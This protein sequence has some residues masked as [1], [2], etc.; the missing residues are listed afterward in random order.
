MLSS[1]R[2][3]MLV[4]RKTWPKAKNNNAH[5]LFWEWWEIKETTQIDKDCITHSGDIIMAANKKFFSEI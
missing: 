1:W 4:I 5:R 2:I 3:E